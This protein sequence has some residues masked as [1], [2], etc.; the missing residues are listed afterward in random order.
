MIHKNVKLDI[1]KAKSFYSV[2]NP[3]KRTNKT[4]YAVEKIFANDIC[5]QGPV[6]GIYLK[7]KQ[8]DKQTTTKLAKLNSPKANKRIGK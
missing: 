4:S 2:N 6:S 8:T 7:N 5:D 1:T 3:I